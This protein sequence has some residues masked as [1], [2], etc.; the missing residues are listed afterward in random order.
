MTGKTISHYRILNQLG[1]GGMGVVYKAEDTKLKRIVALKFLPSEFTRD[2]DARK[3]FLREAQ[4]ASTLQHRNICTIHEVTES[5][6]G[7]LY[8]VMDYYQGETL[9][10]ILERG[11]VQVN[12]ALTII[13]QVAEG[14]AE[15]HKH[16]IIHRDIK[17][18]NIIVTADGIVKILDFGLA[19]A[20]NV[21]TITMMGRTPGTVAYMS[22]EQAVGG[23]V[24]RR[25]DL[26]SLGV[27]LYE[28]LTGQRPFQGDVEQGLVYAIT[29]LNQPSPRSFNSEIPI[30][31]ERIIQKALH[32]NPNDRTA[33]VEGFLAQLKDAQKDKSLY[34]KLIVLFSNVQFLTRREKIIVAAI[35]VCIIGVVIGV[36]LLHRNSQVQWAETE[37]LPEINTFAHDDKFL[38]AFR[39]ARNVEGLIPDNPQFQ[40]AL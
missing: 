12:N 38:A 11:P 28:M 2:P 29:N 4:T 35:V 3:R 5:V 21:S 7:Q 31:I 23:I 26:W 22:P 15:A 37:I 39:L 32:K 24:D 33:S 19:K 13:E 40:Q 9:K 16:G 10:Q 25:S 8:I 36:R 34:Q 30:S 6:D 1:S 27:V 20:Q 14:I 18:A 17:P